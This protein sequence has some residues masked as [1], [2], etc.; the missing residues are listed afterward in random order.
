[1]YSLNPTN[2]YLTTLVA[3]QTPSC[4]YGASGWSVSVTGPQTLSFTNFG[5][6][7]NDFSIRLPYYH[8]NDAGAYTI[9]IATVYIN[10]I[11]YG[12]SP[13]TSLVAP[14]SYILT[15]MDPC[16]VTTLTI[17]PNTFENL[18]AFAGYTTKSLN[19]YTFD[20]V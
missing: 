8:P 5:E 3:K 9:E 6:N 15:L 11:G 16:L 20:D 12:I 17:L 4:G 19:K 1:M 7:T 2:P 10:S 18:V 13:L 14:A